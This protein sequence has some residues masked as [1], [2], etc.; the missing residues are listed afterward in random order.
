MFIS[1][2]QT[3]FDTVKY[4]TSVSDSSTEI[5]YDTFLEN[6][7]EYPIKNK[8]LFRLNLNKFNPILLDTETGEWEIIKRDILEEKEH[9]FDILLSL[10]TNKYKKEKENFSDYKKG[11]NFIKN[12]KL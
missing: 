11:L 6:L 12:F 3:P 10:N 9:S 4:I 8:P 7:L 2:I 1:C 5:F